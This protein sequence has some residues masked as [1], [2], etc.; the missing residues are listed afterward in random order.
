MTEYQRGYLDGYREDDSRDETL[1]EQEADRQAGAL[2]GGAT[3]KSEPLADYWLG[4][5]HG[6]AHRKT[7]QPGEGAVQRGE[8]PEGL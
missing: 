1:G 3:I 2:L 4:Y 5:Y 8:I 7:G 6:R